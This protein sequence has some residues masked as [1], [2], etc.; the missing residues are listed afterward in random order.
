VSRRE[1]WPAHGDHRRAAAVSAPPARL[2][3]LP[4]VGYA[5]L[6]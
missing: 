5:L 1:R 4:G 6:P 3:T 2:V